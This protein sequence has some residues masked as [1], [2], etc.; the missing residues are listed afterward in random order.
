MAAMETFMPGIRT[1]NFAPCRAGGF[2]GN[3]LTHSSF[4]PAKSVS[5][6]M[7]TVALTTRS[8][9]VPAALRMADTF[10]KHCLVCSW[11]VSPTIFP[12]AG[13]CGLVPETNTR[14]AARTAWLYVGGGGGALGVRMISLAITFSMLILEGSA[15][16]VGP[17]RAGGHRLQRSEVLPEQPV[18]LRGH[19]EVAL[20]EAVDLV[21]PERDFGFAPGQQN[22]GMMTL[23]FGERSYAIHEIERLLEVGEGEGASDVVLVDHAPPRNNF[24]QRLEFLA[25]ERRHAATA[26]D[27]FLVG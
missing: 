18:N 14:P 3:H 1:G 27:A 25:L 10:S 9:E 4:I 6:R 22:V 19:D 15:A 16:K 20:G 11:I 8:R 12:V 5:S 24:V 7:M 23:F 26:R 13:S 21:R 17:L 2:A